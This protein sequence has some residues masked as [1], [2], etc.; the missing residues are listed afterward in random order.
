MVLGFDI[1]DPDELPGF[2][3]PWANVGPATSTPAAR[4]AAKVNVFIE[5]L[6]C[7]DLPFNGKEI[8]PCR[9]PARSL[10]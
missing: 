3:V 4:A 9:L 7:E 2:V 8:S 10:K 6:L 5:R 1:V